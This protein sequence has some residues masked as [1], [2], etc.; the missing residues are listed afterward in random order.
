MSLKFDCCEW[1]PVPSVC[2]PPQQILGNLVLSA[3]SSRPDIVTHLS[4]N[5]RGPKED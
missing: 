5:P 3:L 2:F 1:L 4:L